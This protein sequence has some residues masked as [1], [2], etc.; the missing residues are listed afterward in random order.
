[1]SI[2]SYS[3]IDLNRKISY[4]KN[5]GDNNCLKNFTSFVFRLF[6]F[7]LFFSLLIYTKA[8]RYVLITNKFT[9]KHKQE[10]CI[11]EA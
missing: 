4:W 8:D 2:Q 9:Y 5:M 1:M 11:T 6:F 3:N 10:I 7:F